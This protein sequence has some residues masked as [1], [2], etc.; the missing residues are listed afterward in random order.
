MEAAE[1]KSFDA[2]DATG[3][4][5]EL[6]A[7]EKHL[8]GLAVTVTR[9]CT[10]C[11]GG[12]IQGALD[13]GIPYDSVL[14]ALDLAAAVNAGVTVRTAIESAKLNGTKEPC[15]E[16]AEDCCGPECAVGVRS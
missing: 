3:S 7:R 5:N 11:T 2:V 6:S 14:A 1:F 13:D 9:G 10:A 8:V 16:E 4:T 15:C 12:R